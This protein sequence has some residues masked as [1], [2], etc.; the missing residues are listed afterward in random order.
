MKNS[1]FKDTSTSSNNFLPHKGKLRASSKI[2]RFKYYIK[3]Y[4]F[5]KPKQEDFPKE[6]LEQDPNFVIERA[7]NSLY[8]GIKLNDQKHGKGLN[9]FQ[10]IKLFRNFVI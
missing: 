1:L 6:S 4:N 9:N 2:I 8:F 3:I 7:T 10:S 5:S